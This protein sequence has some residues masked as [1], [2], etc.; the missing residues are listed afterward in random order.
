M[1]YLEAQLKRAYRE[2]G[3]YN[4]IE[5]AEGSWTIRVNSFRS[6]ENR[7][8]CGLTILSFPIRCKV[9]LGLLRMPVAGRKNITPLPGFFRISASGALRF[10]Y[11]TAT[12]RFEAFFFSLPPYQSLFSASPPNFLWEIFCDFYCL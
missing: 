6:S 1:V 11:V 5:G 12:G 9:P 2:A 3:S 4:S 10:G 8:G 7:K